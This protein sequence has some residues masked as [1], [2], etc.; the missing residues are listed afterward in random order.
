MIIETWERQNL[1]QKSMELPSSIDRHPCF[2]RNTVK[3]VKI[4]TTDLEKS[5]ENATSHVMFYFRY[6]EGWMRQCISIMPT[7]EYMKNTRLDNKE[8]CSPSKTKGFEAIHKGKRC[9][10]QLPSTGV[11]LCFS[12]WG[13]ANAAL[14]QP[15]HRSIR[16]VKIQDRQ[17]HVLIKCG[18][19]QNSPIPVV[20]P[21]RTWPLSK[22]SLWELLKLLSILLS[23]G[24]SFCPACI[25]ET[26]SYLQGD[27]I[28]K[29]S[30]TL[31][32]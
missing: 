11:V 5:F 4:Q 19:S 27:C 32:V 24:L 25:Q 2:P 6:V 26:S 18:G 12:H 30:E 13:N 21:W 1:K 17:Y 20:G 9:G 14:I 8:T 29:D 10:C 3:G 28:Y 31:Q 23:Y 16:K 15:F 7:H 22:N